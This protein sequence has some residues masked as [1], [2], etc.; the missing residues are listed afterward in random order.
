M[1]VAFWSGHSHA[2]YAGSTWYAD[3]F[4]HNLHDH[5]VAH[6]NVDSV[7]GMGATVLSEGN[8]MSQLRGFGSAA[9]EQIAGQRLAARRYGRAGDQ[10]FWGHGIPAMLM[11]LSEQPPE[12]ADPVL[13]ALH[14]QISGGAG[15][16][17]GLGSWWHT[18]EDTVDKIDPDFL[19]RDATIY[20]LLLYRLCTLPVLP[21]DY[22][23]VVSDLNAVV[24]VLRA[25]VG[26][27]LDLNPITDELS[28]LD[29]AVNRL[30]A[31]IAASDTAD[32]RASA[33]LNRCLVR[34]GHALIPIDYTTSG[35][36]DH[37]GAVPTQPLPALQPAASLGTMDSESDAYHFLVTRLVRE[38]NRILQGLREA[39]AAIDETLADLNKT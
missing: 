28:R 16:G 25:K 7:G 18:P 30:H 13:L 36:F 20:T 34:V 10:S 21:L 32:A 19:R 9:I 12:N 31:T 29:S 8:S 5:C 6:V 23:A 3:T 24:A 38:R 2:R 26:D 35:P 11:S 37:D 15:G 14:H 33:A 17:G 22:T 4:W 1:R 39:T 27:H